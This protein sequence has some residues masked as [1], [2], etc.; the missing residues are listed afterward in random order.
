M[1]P[2]LKAALWA[3]ALSLPPVG[4][5]VY[6]QLLSPDNWIFEGGHA[7]MNGGLHAAP[8]PIAGAGLPVLL[9]AGAYWVVRRYRRKSG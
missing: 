7:W 9:V 5:I 3:I 4:T 6:L 2:A 1:T 8:A